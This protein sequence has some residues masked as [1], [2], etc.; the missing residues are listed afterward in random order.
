VKGCSFYVAVPGKQIESFTLDCVNKGNEFSFNLELYTFFA[1][2]SSQF[3]KQSRSI[4][5]VASFARFPASLASQG[6][7]FAAGN[8]TNREREEGRGKR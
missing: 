5:F 7:V 3:T 1:L 4:R 8:Q 6:Q 2:L